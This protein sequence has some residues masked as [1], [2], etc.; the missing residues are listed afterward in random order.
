MD[1]HTLVTL[2]M[3]RAAT[4]RM[5]VVDLRSSYKVAVGIRI[6]TQ[7][8]PGLRIISLVIVSA[9][10]MKQK[11][12]LR[13]QDGMFDELPEDEDDDPVSD[14]DVNSVQMVIC[15]TPEG[16]KCLIRDPSSVIFCSAAHQRVFKEIEDIVVLDTGKHLKWRHLHANAFD[17]RA[18]MV[19]VYISNTLLERYPIGP[20][21]Q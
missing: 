1:R 13:V 8:T 17:S 9:N 5:I 12:I 2:V 19:L 3:G 6:I 7:T 15:M 10:V 18:G 21:F 20:D 14:S 16:S 11:K 4:D